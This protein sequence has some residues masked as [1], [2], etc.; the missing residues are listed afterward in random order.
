MKH[1]LNV[2]SCTPNCIVY[3]ETG[4]KPLQIDIDTRMISFWSKLIQP[5]CNK[6]SVIVYNIMLSRFMYNN[7]T[8]ASDF[9]WF[10]HI[11]NILVKC[12]M[13]NVWEHHDFP[14]H[15][16]LKKSI[17]TKLSDLFINDWFSTLEISRKCC[18]YK[19]FKDKFGFEDYLIKTP[20]NFLKYVI[21]FRTRNNKFPV[22]TGSWNNVTAENRICELCTKGTIGYEFDY[23]LDCDFFAENRRKCLDRN[24]F[25]SP[26]V[27]KF[28]YVMN[29]SPCN[30][31]YTKFCKFVKE[32]I[33]KFR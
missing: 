20:H 28:K 25:T 10:K 1:V 22:E 29:L 30:V 3:G 9:K 21:M 5:V 15:V 12:G 19:L 2:K 32:I 6:I 18:C 27:L 13:I 23:L 11:K 33:V 4:V 16:W 17:N 7:S 26:N 8:N 14:N 31:K 24:L